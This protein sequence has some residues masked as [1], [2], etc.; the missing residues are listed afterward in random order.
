MKKR[1]LFKK[2][3]LLGLVSS[4]SA[5]SIIVSSCSFINNHNDGVFRY[6]H[7]IDVLKDN[8]SPLNPNFNNTPIST[9]ARSSLLNLVT[10][11]TSTE[12]ITTGTSSNSSM[13]GVSKFHD[14]LMLEAASELQV[15]KSET[16]MNNY[17]N[18][19]NPS[20]TPYTFKSGTP[21][22]KQQDFDKAI[23][24]GTIFRFK[25]TD[26]KNNPLN[27]WVDK[28]G[29]RVKD[30]KGNDIPVT[31]H[32]FER[33][34]ESYSLSSKIKYNR[35]GYFLSLLGL[36]I[37]KTVGYKNDNGSYVNVV[38]PYYNIENFANSN[39]DYFTVYLNEPYPY[40]LDLFSKE[41]FSA[42][43]AENYKVKNISANPN[44]PLKIITS[45]DQQTKS[46]SYTIDRKN[47]DFNQLYGS[48]DINNFTKDMW[49]GGPYFISDFT[50]TQIIFMLN[51]EYYKSIGNNLNLE[52]NRIPKIVETYGSGTI[53][54]YYELFKS[55]QNDYLPQVPTSRKSEAVE[56][57]SKPSSNPALKLFKNSKTPQSNY[58]TYTPKAYVASSG[59]PEINNNISKTTASFIN[60]W[61]SEDSL[62]VRLGLVGLINH[63]FLSYINL[64][65]TGDFQLSSIPYGNF[66]NYYET[67]EKIDS[68]YGGLPRPYSDYVNSSVGTN[69]SVMLGE[70]TAPIYK[71]TNSNVE[72]INKKINKESF[73]K[74]LM[75]I[76]ASKSS[77][78]ILSAK[79]GE[80]SFT[81][82]YNNYL[83]SLKSAIENLS[84]GL[85]KFIINGRNGTNPTA[86]EWFN[87]QSSPIGFSYWNPDYN[88]VGTWLE[89]S[90]LLSSVIV[91][92]VSYEANPSSNAHNAWLTYLQ[93]MVTAVKFMQATL[94][95]I[96]VNSNT[97]KQYIVGQNISNDPYALDQKIQGAFNSETLKSL[98]GDGAINYAVDTSNNNI[99]SIDK[100]GIIFGKL[101]VE[102]VNYLI[103]MGVI[104]ENEFQKLVDNP[105]LLNTKRNPS[106][107]EE[108]LI[109]TKV[110]KGGR[111]EDFSKYLG[112]YCGQS[113]LKQLW[114]TTVNDSD[115]WYIPRSEA[116]L[117]DLTFSLVNPDYQVNVS[118]VTNLSFRDFIWK[119]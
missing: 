50:S 93:A 67:V 13:N 69:A 98:F 95:D 31:S 24:E 11:K 36:N 16:E 32:D 87:N 116:G 106:T 88:G 38:D 81:T 30:S 6:F 52:G 85:I 72:I 118:T 66:E 92:N 82:N 55:G 111:S 28:N 76:G 53:D 57:F 90:T 68:F 2:L 46:T 34:I 117:K 64:P 18:N 42:V 89:S 104:D 40:A 74:S 105:S 27:Y 110:I 78:L 3:S 83:I 23:S 99:N 47:T 10:Y 61:S 21:L 103:R 19:T 33:A 14:T 26:E 108:L 91:N 65:S 70:F 84:D 54:T 115:Y 48:G 100:P 94:Q 59:G 51:D 109:G 1:K 79:F 96:R 107:T 77:P 56:K 37:D 75:N 29:K 60:D 45:F 35:N 114:A 63:C 73:K 9:F 25:L 102:M 22:N 58:V 71:Y 15:F 39:K 8:N 43:P 49:Y 101:G 119:K 112:T 20:T 12:E 41:Y 80:S 44:S 113:N 4:I 17:L 62:T 7:N 5:V 97:T 86:N